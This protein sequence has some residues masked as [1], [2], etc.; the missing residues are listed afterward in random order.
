MQKKTFFCRLCACFF[1][2]CVLSTNSKAKER[3]R[4][5]WQPFQA[6]KIITGEDTQKILD[7][8][9]KYVDV[10]S[11]LAESELHSIRYYKFSFKE[12]EKHIIIIVSHDNNLIMQDLNKRIKGGGGE[13]IINRLSNEIV[14]YTLSK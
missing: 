6:D 11:P 9:N 3:T 10:A 7:V 13:F 5:E 8:F 12:D 1:I 2:F 14:S 4:V